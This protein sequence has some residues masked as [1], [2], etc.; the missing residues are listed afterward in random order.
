MA[1]L[2]LKDV[3]EKLHSALKKQA[4]RHRRSLNQEILYCLERLTGLNQ[5]VADERRAWLQASEQSLRKV[6]DNPE[7]AVYDA[8]LQ[9]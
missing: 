3:P 8:L 2:T 5:P 1:T 9:K 4:D 6:W 7:D